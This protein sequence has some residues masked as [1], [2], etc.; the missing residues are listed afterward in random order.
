MLALRLTHKDRRAER[1]TI[2]T[3]H[4]CQ[5]FVVFCGGVKE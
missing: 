4:P 2:R 1:E 3:V 5:Q